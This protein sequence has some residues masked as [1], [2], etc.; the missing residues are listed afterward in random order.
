VVVVVWPVSLLLLHA[1]VCVVVVTN[2]VPCALSFGLVDVVPQ[3]FV[4]SAVAAPGN[5]ASNPAESKTA[6]HFFL[7]I[8]SSIT[9]G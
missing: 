6:K 8:L 1:E 5:A 3:S 7:M 9:R 4:L 2:G